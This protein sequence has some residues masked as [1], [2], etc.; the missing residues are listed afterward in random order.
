MKKDEN[1]SGLDQDCLDEITRDAKA[2]GERSCFED[3]FRDLSIVT[4]VVQPSGSGI[5]GAGN[6]MTS[7]YRQAAIKNQTQ[8]NNCDFYYNRIANTCVTTKPEVAL[9]AFDEYSKCSDYRMRQ[10]LVSANQTSNVADASS[11]KPK[12][13]QQASV[14][15]LAKAF[16]LAACLLNAV[17]I[18]IRMRQK[19]WRPARVED[20]E[21]EGERPMLKAPRPTASGS[22]P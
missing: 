5:S 8:K 14:M 1:L 16:Y 2:S 18:S 7:A 13:Q 17:P 10:A 15:G 22:A 4:K 12:Y 21:S 19:A 11:L 9:K 6:D 20:V 3:Q